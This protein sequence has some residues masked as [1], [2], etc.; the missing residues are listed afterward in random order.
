[1]ND[2]LFSEF[3]PLSR[4]RWREQAV[5]ELRGKDYDEALRWHLPEGIS[6]DPYCTA[7]DLA[8]VPV[9]AIQ[10]A[11]KAV[12]GWENRAEF[13][14]ENERE[15][16]ALAREALAGGADALAFDVRHLTAPNLP[17][18]LDG[19]KLSDTPVSFR[20]AGH[21]PALVRDLKTVAPYQLR[22]SLNDTA[23]ADWDAWADVFRQTDDSPQFRFATVHTATPQP[24]RALTETLTFLAEALHQLAD[25]GLDAGRVLGRLEFSRTATPDFLTELA[26]LRAL[27][28]LV[29]KIGE[30]YGA[31]PGLVFVHANTRH[32]VPPAGAVEF[33]DIVRAT[34]ES[35][36]AVAGGADALTVGNHA[37][38]DP[39]SRRIARNVSNLLKHEAHLARVADPAAGSYFLEKLTWELAQAAWVQFVNHARTA[40]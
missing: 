29:G 36:I 2:A 4:D 7:D 34:T 11:Q 38:P 23:H 10:A 3:S 1:M 21:G 22:G 26:L 18:L 9:A 24:V 5:K 8:D 12:P 32:A 30:A 20:A 25:R 31:A 37:E 27:R 6:L 40:F 19:L 35:M 17:R 28:F 14:V 15:A 16:N 39:F 33:E 13:L